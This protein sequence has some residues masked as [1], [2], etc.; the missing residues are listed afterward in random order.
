MKIVQAFSF[1]AAHQ[2]PNV[3]ETHRCHRMHGHSYRVELKLDGAVDAFTGFVADFFDIE[4]AFKPYLEKLDHHCLN[5]ISG[6]EIR[7]PKISRC[8]FGIRSNPLCRNWR[9]SSFMKRA[10]AGR[11]M[12]DI[13]PNLTKG[14]AITRWVLAILYFGAGALHLYLADA[15]LLIIPDWVP[16][17]RHVILFTGICEIIGAIA[18][19]TTRFRYAAAALPSRS[20][21]WLFWPANIKHAIEGIPL[22][23]MQLGWWYHGPRLAF[24]PVLIWWA[25]FAGEVIT[26]PFG[27]GRAPETGKG[28]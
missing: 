28:E 8:G 22:G 26:W 15:L 25:L 5:E 18:L 21:L 10:I 3:P 4:A 2:L 13:N 1:E 19:L 14:R 12:K 7:P 20:M 11:N 23:E 27:K 9:A 24:Q 16:Y 17:P 6:L